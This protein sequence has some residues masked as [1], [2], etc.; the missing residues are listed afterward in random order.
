MKNLNG[1]INKY[2][3]KNGNIFCNSLSLIIPAILRCGKAN[4]ALIAKEMSRFNG[5]DFHTNDMHLYRFLQSEDFQI[6]DSFWRMHIKL[7]FDWVST[8]RFPKT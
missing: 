7:L 8:S 2:F 5:Q 1:I 3:L 6:D 4:T